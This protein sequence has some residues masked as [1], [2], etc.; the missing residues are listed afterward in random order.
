MILT[1]SVILFATWFAMRWKRL[2]IERLITKDKSLKLTLERGKIDAIDKIATVAI[3]CIAGFILLGATNHNL[4]ALI[5][6]GG[7]GGLALAFASQQIIANFFGGLMI[8]LTHPFM[9]GDSILLPDRSIE[10]TVEEIGWY[11]TRI[12]SLDKRPI[13]IPNS[14][15]STQIVINPSRMSHRQI[16]EI[17]YISPGD[18]QKVKTLLNELNNM[19]QRNSELDT[20]LPH[21]AHFAAF[22]SSSLE[23]VINAFTRTTDYDKYL[24]IK[25]ELLLSISGLV[26]KEGL[27]F[28]PYIPLL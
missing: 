8:Y 16:K 25:E 6:F 10:G 28:T 22:R 13:Y 4:N 2:L 24:K 20:A 1:V 11:V 26:E 23:I 7:V 12:S 21:Y 27:E 19:L 15:F 18:L 3:L 17:I 14:L 9:I 5:A